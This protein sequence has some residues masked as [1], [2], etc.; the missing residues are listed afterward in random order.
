MRLLSTVDEPNNF[1]FDTVNVVCSFGLPLRQIYTQQ[2]NVYVL[3]LSMVIL[4]DLDC[5]KV[6]DENILVL[7]SGGKIS[8]VFS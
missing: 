7:L 2:Y 4:E 1:P 3:P 6:P 5:V 8:F